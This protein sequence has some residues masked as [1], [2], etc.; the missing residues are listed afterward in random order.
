[1]LKTGRWDLT[2]SAQTADMSRGLVTLPLKYNTLERY[3]GWRHRALIS[4]LGGVGAMT[5]TH[6]DTLLAF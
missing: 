5:T 4:S 1:M 6:T 2:H 3:F